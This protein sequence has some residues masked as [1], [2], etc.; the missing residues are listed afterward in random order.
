[1]ARRDEVRGGGRGDDR[2]L[3]RVVDRNIQT[4]LERRRAEE[5]ARSTQERIAEWLG[6]FAGSMPFVW[7][8]AALVAVWVGMNVGLLPGPRFDPDFVKLAT[9]A[10]VE[11]IFLTTFVLVTQNRM[12]ALAD[13]RADLDLQISLLAEHELTR[14]IRISDEM[15]RRLGVPLEERERELADTRRDVDP[16]EVLDR[17]EDATSRADDERDGHVN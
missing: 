10:S 16:E 11:A 4:L 15:A 8:H 3:A 7:I 17:I 14:L 5:R 6:R 9:A 13:Q 12:A 2:G 1:M